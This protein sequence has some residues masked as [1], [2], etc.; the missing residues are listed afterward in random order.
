MEV[1]QERSGLDM[2]ATRISLMFYSVLTD[3]IAHIC[4]KFNVEPVS[5]TFFTHDCMSG[6]RSF[7][8]W[9]STGATQLQR[10]YD[11]TCLQQLYGSFLE[12]VLRPL[13]QLFC[14][15]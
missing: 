12:A 1:W 13:T 7:M 15:L 2:D 11:P 5:S 3:L 9:S 10:N 6:R 14:D 8:L 4:F